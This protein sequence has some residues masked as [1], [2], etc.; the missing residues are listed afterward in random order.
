MLTFRWE[1]QECRSGAAAATEIAAA[2]RIE[3]G[4]ISEGHFR[5]NQGEALA[6]AGL[7]E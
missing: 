6:A 5:W 4:Q 2:F 7:R 1:V 3:K